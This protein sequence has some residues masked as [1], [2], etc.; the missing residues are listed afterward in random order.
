MPAQT[1]TPPEPPTRASRETRVSL[2][3]GAGAHS[4]FLLDALLG[5]PKTRPPEPIGVR[6]HQPP[7][8]LKRHR[9]PTL[10]RAVPPAQPPL[11]CLRAPPTRSHPPTPHPARRQSP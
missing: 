10:P 6:A 4:D 1:L 11:P 5:A 2:R 8:A 3:I 9:L 7:P